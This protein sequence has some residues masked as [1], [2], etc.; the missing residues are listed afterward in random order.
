MKELLEKLDSAA[1]DLKD[2]NKFVHLFSEDK[3]KATLA[4]LR[5][6]VGKIKWFVNASK[7][8][9]FKHPQGKPI[10]CDS[11]TGSFVSIRPCGEEYEGKT[12]LGIYVGD[13]GLGS[14]IKIDDDSVVCEWSSFNPGILI[15]ELNKIVYGCESWW[16][17]ITKQ[18]EL[19][20]ISD[21]DIESVWYVKA[22]KQLGTADNEK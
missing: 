12:Y 9:T 14:S 18:S 6:T 21:L 10:K 20:N 4:R 17:F 16:G 15:P 8:K 7:I 5:E 1:E 2:F 22:L 19:R 13:V 3:A 11:T